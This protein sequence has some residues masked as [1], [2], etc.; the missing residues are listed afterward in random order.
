MTV[1]MIKRGEVNRVLRKAGARFSRRQAVLAQ[2][3]CFTV[4]ESG[5]HTVQIEDGVMV[6]YDCAACG[7]VQVC[8]QGI[9]AILEAKQDLEAAGFP[10]QI[11]TVRIALAAYDRDA[12]DEGKPT[13]AFA[14]SWGVSRDDLFVSGFGRDWT[15]DVPQWLMVREVQS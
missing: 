5:L 4:E 13:E 1:Q 15:A 12:V 7:A 2:R 14:A 8:V 9:A 10:V 11:K 3:G 6:N